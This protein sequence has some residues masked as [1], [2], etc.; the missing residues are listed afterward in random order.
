MKRRQ[1]IL[2]TRQQVKAWSPWLARL[3]SLL[4]SL[5][6]E[7]A[8]KLV[9]S[10]QH[11]PSLA[12]TPGFEEPDDVSAS[13]MISTAGESASEAEADAVISASRRPSVTGSPS[14]PGS[15]H[16]KTLTAGAKAGKDGKQA[17]G[18]KGEGSESPQLTELV[19]QLS[20]QVTRLIYLD[21]LVSDLR[22]HRLCI[23]LMVAKLHVNRETCLTMPC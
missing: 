7:A 9:A 22:S 8:A 20:V 5:A 18:C 2:H 12:T 17:A 19:H 11:V 21:L 4:G 1:A 10:N 15:A 6:A 13:L 23:D 3:H 16:R 14:R